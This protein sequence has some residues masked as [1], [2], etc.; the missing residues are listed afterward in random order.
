MAALLVLVLPKSQPQAPMGP[1]SPMST[2]ALYKL[3]SSMP[4]HC[5]DI[6]WSVA[7]AF[8]NREPGPMRKV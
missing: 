3:Q 2:S 6:L 5:L 7:L 1:A 4:S 8:M